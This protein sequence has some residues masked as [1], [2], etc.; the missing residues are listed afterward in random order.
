ME[1]KLKREH[2]VYIPLFALGV[3]SIFL[4]LI[5]IAVD[6]SVYKNAKVELKLKLEEICKEVA[7]NPVLQKEATLSFRDHVQNILG[8]AGAIRKI[9]DYLNVSHAL[10]IIP[11]MPGGGEYCPNNSCPSSL[12]KVPSPV[13]L[14]CELDESSAE[15]PSKDCFFTGSGEEI[16]DPPFSADSQYPSGFWDDLE[17]AG[18]TVACEMGGW[19]DLF[20]SPKRYVFAKTVWS[21]PLRNSFEKLP[22]DFNA[23]PPG[24]VIA[25]AT[26]LVTKAHDPRFRFYPQ[27]ISASDPVINYGYGNVPNLGLPAGDF[28]QK[29]DPLYRFAEIIPPVPTPGIAGRLAFAWPPVAPTPGVPGYLLEVPSTVG[30]ASKNQGGL[31]T[32]SLERCVP[33]GLS[34]YGA[35][36]SCIDGD[37]DDDD[38]VNGDNCVVLSDREEMLAACMNPL[39]LVRNVFL[40]TIVELASRHGGLRA[41]T[42]ILHVNP[43][44]RNGTSEADPIAIP[45]PPVRMVQYGDDLAKGQYQIPFVFFNGGTESSDSK[46][47]PHKNGWLNPFVITPQVPQGNP[48]DPWR[49]HHALITQQLRYCYHL[50]QG[51]QGPDGPDAGLDRYLEGVDLHSQNQNF[52]PDVFQWAME[53]GPDRYPLAHHY[54]SGG[55]L[56]ERNC[57]WNP[58]ACGAG[59]GAPAENRGLNAAE[60][61]AS[62][63]STQSCP[64]IQDG[65]P[66]RDFPIGDAQYDPN[67]N[68]IDNPATPLD[69]RGRCTGAG[70][71]PL[72]TSTYDLRPDILGT[73]KYISQQQRGINSPGV[74]PL[75]PAAPPTLNEPFAAASTLGPG[76][77]Y[78]NAP[79]IKPHVLLVTHQR[80][81]PAEARQ[82]YD[83]I[84][85]SPGNHLEDSPITIVYLPATEIDSTVQ[86][87]DLMKC[88][89][90]VP[91]P[92]NCP[93][94]I[95]PNN[96][97]LTDP[98]RHTNELFLLS[99]Y[100]PKYGGVAGG[101][102]ALP[103]PNSSADEDPVFMVSGPSY[104]STSNFSSEQ[105]RFRGYWV[106]LHGDPR[107]NVVQTARNIF[108]RRI[109]RTEM[110]L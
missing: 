21:R 44:H 47:Q 19:V 4:V 52:E 63:G 64:Y 77:P 36:E 31:Q 2:G 101:G 34:D 46:L 69:E 3:I 32:G 41:G 74:F 98:K 65:L 105:D 37:C 62:L 15:N 6:S 1:H 16:P 25:V 23:Y 95:V 88:A 103:P 66:S 83:Q 30:L 28:R 109:L 24:L 48:S 54:P 13:A 106:F 58:G 87:I 8:R 85:N 22:G 110:K 84:V 75:V 108:F 89:F 10:M 43:Q 53:A 68:F 90:N 9:P 33:P 45:N 12:P 17:D 104:T 71:A 55:V 14:G 60:L 38:P 49:R 59:S 93:N 78:I 67:A 72:S 40:S 81:R 35:L 26:E 80:L 27:P 100:L 51:Y 42:E 50:Y 79:I 76:T 82:I 102:S 107:Q 97:G 94:G 86:A 91:G 70:P 92:A 11:T 18:N 96:S 5:G 99:P 56:W 7:Y 57:P 39:V 29:Y 61:V 73:L 20:F